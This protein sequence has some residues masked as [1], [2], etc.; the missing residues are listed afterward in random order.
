MRNGSKTKASGCTHASVSASN[1][2]DDDVVEAIIGARLFVASGTVEISSM[3]ILVLELVLV[4]IDVDEGFTNAE[5]IIMFVT[6]NQAMKI[7]AI[8]V[9]IVVDCFSWEL[10]KMTE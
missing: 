8:A 9:F 3:E 7:L 2:P 5:A 1:I 6:V 4:I 10:K